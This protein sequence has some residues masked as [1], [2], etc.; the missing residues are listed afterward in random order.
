MVEKGKE[1][2]SKDKN[3]HPQPQKDIRIKDATKFTYHYESGG[4]KVLELEKK[5]LKKHKVTELEK[6]VMEL[7]KMDPV[8]N[9]FEKMTLELP[10][11]QATTA[12]DSAAAAKTHGLIIASLSLAHH[13]QY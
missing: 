8:T 2:L 4:D 5:D 10:P 7:E 1:Q 12:T 11:M 3:G 9:Q 13:E 6:H